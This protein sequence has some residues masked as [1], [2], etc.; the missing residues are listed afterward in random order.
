MMFRLV[1]LAGILFCTSTFAAD[2]QDI[3]F[4][5]SDAFTVMAT[6][7]GTVTYDPHFLKVSLR[8]AVLQKNPKL[9]RIDRVTGYRIG[10][11]FDNGTAGWDTKRWSNVIR[12]DEVMLADRTVDLKNPVVRIPSTEFHCAEAGWFLKLI[13]PTTMAQ[14]VQPMRTATSCNFLRSRTRC[15]K[16]YAMQIAGSRGFQSRSSVRGAG[17]G[18]FGTG[19]HI[20]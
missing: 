13:S 14:S 1:M 17:I 4:T 3:Q 11:A 15:Q 16:N 20:T 5:S 12:V 2:S 19:T 18:Y 10:V 7:K 8:D 9:Q 6:A